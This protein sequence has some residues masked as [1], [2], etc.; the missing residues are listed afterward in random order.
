MN[1]RLS[2]LCCLTVLF[3]LLFSVG[4]FALAEEGE[5]THSAWCNNP[6]VCK[7]CGAKGLEIPDENITHIGEPMW[8]A[9]QFTHWE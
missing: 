1:K 7:D 9:D 4:A 5:C 6:T 3:M 2:L 8:Y